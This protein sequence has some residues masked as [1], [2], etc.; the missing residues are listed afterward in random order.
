MEHNDFQIAFWLISICFALFGLIVTILGWNVNAQNAR[1]LAKRKDIHE[2]VDTCIEALI[3]LED[4]AYS[5]WL[6]TDSETRPYQLIV[7]H[8]R[9]TLR[10]KQL[11]ELNNHPIPSS[12]LITLR[13]YCTMD[14][15]SKTVP[16][17]SED[18]RIKHIS[19]AAT[20]ILQSSILQKKWESS[21]PA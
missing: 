13:R 2:A 18:I 16:L 3:D 6:A 10:L 7:S 15:E 5:F 21:S 14:A 12:D 19:K 8:A 20:S 17:N 1:S 4:C 11:Q 9:L